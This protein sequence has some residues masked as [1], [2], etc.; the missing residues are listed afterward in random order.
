MDTSPAFVGGWSGPFRRCTQVAVMTLGFASLL[1]NAFLLS[2]FLYP[3][4]QITAEEA[5]AMQEQASSISRGVSAADYNDGHKYFN[6]EK[7]HG[8]L[9]INEDGTPAYIPGPPPPRV[10]EANFI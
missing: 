10:S 3:S 6:P 9:G 1:L 7:M 2:R 4:D 5:S 8:P